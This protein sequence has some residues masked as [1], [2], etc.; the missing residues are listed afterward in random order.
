MP[1]R[2]HSIQTED[3]SERAYRCCNLAD[4]VI[5]SMVGAKPWSELSIGDGRRITQDRRGA[6]LRS[7]CAELPTS[8]QIFLR[9]GLDLVVEDPT[10]DGRVRLMEGVKEDLHLSIS[11]SQSSFEL[12]LEQRYKSRR[13]PLRIPPMLHARTT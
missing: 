7:A 12:Q 2:Q 3:G 1:A 9:A 6:L 13:S 4:R 10:P 5:I 11:V 8:S